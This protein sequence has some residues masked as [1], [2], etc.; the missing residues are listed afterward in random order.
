MQGHPLAALYVSF[1]GK[2]RSYSEVAALL[3]SAVSQ[4]AANVVTTN[5]VLD[6]LRAIHASS[7]GG[8]RE[9]L[10]AAFQLAQGEMLRRLPDADPR[11]LAALARAAYHLDLPVPQEEHQRIV[12]KFLSLVTALQDRHAPKVEPGPP[13][14][15]PGWVQLN[16]SR[17]GAS[18]AT[19]SA[20]PAGDG[21]SDSDSGSVQ[22]LP[23][24]AGTAGVS[25]DTELLQFNQNVSN[26]AWAIL[27]NSQWELQEGQLAALM[28]CVQRQPMDQPLDSTQVL[29]G[30]VRYAASHGE[31]AVKEYV[32]QGGVAEALLNRVLQQ[33]N[34]LNNQNCSDV[35]IR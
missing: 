8:N 35:L 26:F 21:G 31:A 27:S 24:Q 34:I 11:S 4:G 23:V 2:A 12:S 33:L 19:G 16:L 32:E 22:P 18:G 14:P 15:K 7:K 30:L 25:P 1:I 9:D 13:P 28:Q 17:P 20:V 6:R 29:T 3:Q 5:A 10:Q